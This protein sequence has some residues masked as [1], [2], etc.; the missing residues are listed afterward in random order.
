MIHQRQYLAFGL[1]TSQY[2]AGVHAQLDDL[3]RDLALDRCE[4]FGA[5]DDAAAAFAE[6]F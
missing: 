5:I 6:R 3:E 4:L 1:E 2:G